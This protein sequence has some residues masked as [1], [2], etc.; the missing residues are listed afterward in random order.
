[1]YNNAEIAQINRVIEHFFCGSAL[2]LS[3]GTY[4]IE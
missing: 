3:H 2:D 1:M 4:E